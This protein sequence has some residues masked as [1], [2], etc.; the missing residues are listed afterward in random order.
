VNPAMRGRKAATADLTAAHRTLRV[1][2]AY[3]KNIWCSLLGRGGGLAMAVCVEGS[4]AG[5]RA[6]FSWAGG[7][8]CEGAPQGW[9]GIT[10]ARR[11]GRG[12]GKGACL[13]CGSPRLQVQ[14]PPSEPPAGWLWLSQNGRC[15]MAVRTEWQ[16]TP[17]TY[18]QMV[19][20][21]SSTCW[22]HRKGRRIT[23][24]LV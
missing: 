13:A 7:R 20:S 9:P 14:A 5:G 1:S 24:Q 3:R 15:L 22:V 17:G 2:W 12:S 23:F 21:L 16:V 10:K 19:Q 6:V 11:W 18:S 8:V 4:G